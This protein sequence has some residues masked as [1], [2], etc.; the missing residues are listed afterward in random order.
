LRKRINKPF[1]IWIDAIC[2]DQG[3]ED[4]KMQQIPLMGDVYS[5]AATVYVWLGEGDAASDRAM[6][7][8]KGAGFL[9]FFYE[10]LDSEPYVKEM[11]TP[12]VWSAVWALVLARVNPMKHRLPSRVNSSKTFSSPLVNSKL[13]FTFH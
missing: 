4:E 6:K 3:D 9:E 5:K 2:I 11:P 13:S 8:L 10:S 7:Y 1:A 12:R